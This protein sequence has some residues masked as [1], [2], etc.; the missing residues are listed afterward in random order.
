MIHPICLYSIARRDGVSGPEPGVPSAPIVRFGDMIQQTPPNG[1]AYFGWMCE[2]VQR[3]EDA[4]YVVYPNTISPPPGFQWFACNP[5]AIDANLWQESAAIISEAIYAPTPPAL[6]QSSSQTPQLSPIVRQSDSRKSEEGV[7]EMRLTETAEGYALISAKAKRKL[8]A[9]NYTLQ[10]VMVLHRMFA[11]EARNKTAVQLVLH[12]IS[13][14]I[15]TVVME[16]PLDGI[17]TVVSRIGKAIPTAITFPQ[18][19][20]VFSGLLPVLVR[21]RL[22]S[23]P[24]IY[25][26]Q[27]SGWVLPPHCSWLYVHGNAV[28]P[29]DCV[30][31]ETNFQFGISG[32]GHAPAWLAQNSWRLLS[33]SKNLPAI[34]IPFL[35]AHLALMWTLF[36]A[37]GYPPHVLLFIKG[38]TGSLKTAVASLLFNFSADPKNNIPAS[39]RDTSASMEVMMGKYKD[40]VLLVDDFCPA[41]SENARRILE[42]N[43]EQLIR[44][45]GDGIAKS[46][47]NPKLEETH[48]KRPHGLCAITGEDSAGSYSS[49]LRCLFITVQPDTYDKIL[50]AEFQENPALW[51]EYLKIFVDFCTKN[52]DKIISF[53]KSGF[54]ALRDKAAQV[55]SER[56]LVDAYACLSLTAEIVLNFVAPYLSMADSDKMAI[57]ARYDA[58]VLETCRCSAEEAKEVDPVQVFARMVCEGIDKQTLSL[59]GRKE[60]ESKPNEFHGYA[61]GNHWYFWPHEL[62]DFLRRAYELGGKK[63]PLTQARLWEALYLA[64]VLIPPAPRGAG[65]RRF[66]FGVRVSFG[67]R[68]RMI[69]IDPITLKKFL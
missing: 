56:R 39:F 65:E 15:E 42:Q 28:P 14:R 38:V 31:I 50:L 57:Y 45:Y 10:K 66:E 40:R 20:A 35:Y 16:I 64:K 58:A 47:T 3:I 13:S 22:A 12:I 4:V 54:P 62:F 52:A 60:F 29:S 1:V 8:P 5:P 24:H 2:P 19:K 21:E 9:S 23:C 49:L 34:L 55:I 61:E 44:F 37:A 41:A 68:P 6:P 25:V 48:E 53:V 63:F 32:N 67:N 46:R 18:S 33:M 51:T 17:D 11:D 59:A 43:L 30:Q 7:D 27:D 36:D 26:Y 69:R